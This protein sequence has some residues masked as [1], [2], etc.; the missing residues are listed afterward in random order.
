MR[1]QHVRNRSERPRQKRIEGN[2]APDEGI[3]G[4]RTT[5]GPA[6]TTSRSIRGAAATCRSTAPATTSML[7]PSPCMLRNSQHA[8]GIRRKEETRQKE[9]PRFPEVSKWSG[10]RD[11][12]PRRSAWEAD[13]L[14]LNYSRNSI[15][16]GNHRGACGGMQAKKKKKRLPESLRAARRGARNTFPLCGKVPETCFHCVENPRK[17]VSIVWKRLSPPEARVRNDGRPPAFW[18]RIFCRAFSR[19]SSPSAPCAA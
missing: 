5:R 19:A 8:P 9:S 1:P 14:P 17:H 13:I 10:R 6:W 11:S 3:G 12:N 2:L 15:V 4:R 18:R 16:G 7:R